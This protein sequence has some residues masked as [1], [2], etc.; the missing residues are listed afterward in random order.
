[1]VH[2]CQSISLTP[3]YPGMLL[4][5]GSVSHIH[6]ALF[7]PRHLATYVVHN[8]SWG[9]VRAP[10][11]LTLWYHYI[12]TFHL[13]HNGS[14]IWFRLTYTCPCMPTLQYNVMVPH[15]SP[16]GLR[17][18]TQVYYSG[19]GQS[20][21]YTMPYSH[22]AAYVVITLAKGTFWCPQP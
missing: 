17:H 15:I 5:Y 8:T 18:G 21:I 19:M 6:H 20:R 10:A 1:M 9:H 12:S 14:V 3:W 13:C 22:L 7:C 2:S 16:S 4:W 11:A